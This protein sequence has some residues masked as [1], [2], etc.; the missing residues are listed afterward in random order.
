MQLF[1]VSRNH[2]N[3][4]GGDSGQ[5]QPLFRSQF[6]D[7]LVQ[8]G[9]LVHLQQ[10]HRFK[11]DPILMDLLHSWRNGALSDRHFALLGSLTRPLSLPDNSH[12]KP[13]LLAPF[14]A[15]VA[16][17]NLDALERL[18]ASAV[19]FP[20]T[21]VL[22][23][24]YGRHTQLCLQHAGLHH[25]SPDLKV[26]LRVMHM[27]NSKRNQRLRNGT[28]GTVVS[29]VALSV[30]GSEHRPSPWPRL[31]VVEWSAPGGH[32]FRTTV[33]PAVTLE[34]STGGDL[35]LFVLPLLP[36]DAMTIHK[37]VGC[38]LPMVV[39]DLSV[40]GSSTPFAP[41]LLYEALS[42]VPSLECVQLLLPPDWLPALRRWSPVDRF[43][44]S[45]LRGLVTAATS[46][47]NRDFCESLLTVLEMSS[48][49]VASVA[50]GHSGN[51][52]DASGGDAEMAAS[53]GDAEMAEMA[54]LTEMAEMAEMAASGGAAVV[55]NELE[56]FDAQPAAPTQP[57]LAILMLQHG[58]F[59]QVLAEMWSCYLK[60]SR[61]SNAQ[62]RGLSGGFAHLVPLPLSGRSL[63]A[64]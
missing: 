46:E 7:L 27:F 22:D 25:H 16:K 23:E 14:R 29:F 52:G 5:R 31:P 34:P 12:I 57:T 50:P 38:N 51:N 63:M 55:S 49:G 48:D 13:V 56:L 6:W 28:M 60:V 35:F 11:S 21:K 17:A 36:A 58:E 30:A 33:Y 59:D 9:Q 1:P 32:R 64:L 45:A 20:A 41:H 15:T 2:V 26:G 62:G 43:A 42:R 8:K 39:V 61:V 44:A 24:P 3:E 40:A 19:A 47:S 54:E 18:Q 4:S 10:Q 37:S 53:G